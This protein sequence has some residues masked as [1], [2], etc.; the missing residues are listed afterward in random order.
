MH[1]FREVRTSARRLGDPF[2]FRLFVRD[3]QTDEAC[4]RFV[5]GVREHHTATKRMAAC[6]EIVIGTAATTLLAADPKPRGR[7][8]RQTDCESRQFQIG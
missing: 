7:P 5:G 1:P 6:R 8:L 2:D 3:C 4:R